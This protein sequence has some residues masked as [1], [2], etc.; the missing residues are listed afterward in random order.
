M[1]LI[2]TILAGKAETFNDEYTENIKFCDDVGTLDAALKIIHDQKL[3]SFPICRIEITGF[4][5]GVDTLVIHVRRQP[6]TPLP[7]QR[8]IFPSESS[9]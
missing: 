9:Q 8:L 2:Y 3:Y 1:P 7:I 6:C 5:C 4:H